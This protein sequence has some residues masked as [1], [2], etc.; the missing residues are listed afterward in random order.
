MGV[1]FPLLANWPV[2]GQNVPKLRIPHHHWE[3][4]NPVITL[5]DT[6]GFIQ[7]SVVKPESS[8]ESQ[9]IPS[10]GDATSSCV[11]I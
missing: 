9:S 5:Q 2:A 6:L 10:F 3:T 8:R 4:K 7:N 11:D 1:G